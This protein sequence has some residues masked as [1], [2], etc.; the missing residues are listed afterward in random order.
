MS[1]QLFKK[2]EDLTDYQA[3]DTHIQESLKSL[4][5]GEGPDT[6][7]YQ[8]KTKIFDMLYTETRNS[9][10]SFDAEILF[11]SIIDDLNKTYDQVGPSLLQLQRNKE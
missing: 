8:I 4:G 7:F 10:P 9:G 1:D 5:F 2:Q 6:I 11:S 3:Y